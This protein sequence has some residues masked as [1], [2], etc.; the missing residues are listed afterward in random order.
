MAG[1]TLRELEER[2]R[3]ACRLTRE[4][5]LESIDEAHDFLRERGMFTLMPSAA[6]PSL[7]AA[8]HEEPYKAGKRGFAQWPRT[9]YP[10]AFELRDRPDVHVLKIHRGKELYL[11]DDTI[12]IAAPLCRAELA[13]ADAGELG[14]D[15]RRL[16]AHLAAAGPSALDELKEELDLDAAALRRVRTPLERAGAVVTR[17]LVV[18]AKRGGHRH[19][20]E[21]VRFDQYYAG[22]ERDGGAGGLLVT[23]VRAAVVAPEDEARRWFAWRIDLQSVD[24]LVGE[25]V[26]C[27]PEVGWLASRASGS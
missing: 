12:Q 11:S 5:A 26:L 1:L 6:L 10:W 13:R 17:G 15:A 24:D 25:G 27:R 20:S 3:H 22:P 16:V 9:K 14:E 19:T 2:R 18:P 8:C 4:R 23:G 21:L 7:F